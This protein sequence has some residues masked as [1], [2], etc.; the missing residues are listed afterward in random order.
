M[1]APFSGENGNLSTSANLLSLRDIS[2]KKGITFWASPI[3]P[4][5]GISRFD[6]GGFKEVLYGC[7]FLFLFLTFESKHDESKR[8][9]CKH[10]SDYT[11]R[12][13]S[14]REG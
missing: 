12:E 2:L 9:A 4:I 5:R 6:G 14:A 11:Q 1:A 7:G 3:S 13:Q 10:A 8:T